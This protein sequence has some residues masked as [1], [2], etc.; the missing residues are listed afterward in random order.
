MV[1]EA[2][3]LSPVL[4]SRMILNSG[5]VERRIDEALPVRFAFGIW[6]DL[7]HPV[8]D[9]A[10]RFAARVA[11][12]YLRPSFAEVERSGAP[13]HRLAEGMSG[14]RTPSVPSSGM[15]FAATPKL[16]ADQRE[17]L[18]GQPLNF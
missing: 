12:A 16:R 11:W 1:K 6:I 2:G 3:V 4:Y 5:F 13:Q 14:I 7:I 9:L 18:G 17:W 10:G 15:R 8:D